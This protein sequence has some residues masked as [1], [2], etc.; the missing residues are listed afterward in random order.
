MQASATAA[1]EYVDAE[2]V[3]YTA[4]VSN[5]GGYRTGQD[6]NAGLNTDRIAPDALDG[7]LTLS[8]GEAAGPGSVSLTSGLAG[9]PDV[10]SPASGRLTTAL[11][12][13][14]D[15][16][17]SQWSFSQPGVYCVPV[18]WT[19][20]KAG[21]G[22]PVSVRKVLTFAAGVA[23]DTGITS[24]SRGQKL[25]GQGGGQAAGDDAWRVPNQS[26][27][28]SGATILNSGHIDIASTLNG[29]VFGT[30]VKDTT[31]VATG[32]TLWRD[33]ARTV[34]QLLPA[35][36]T[37]VPDN[38]RYAFLGRAG[39]RL[40]QVTETQQTELGLLWPGWSTESIPIDATQSGVTW[41]LD[42]I[43]GPGEFALYK[44]GRTLG[45]VDVLFNTR[46]G[47][48]AADSFEIAKNAHVHGAW[49]F[50]AE[51]AYCLAFTR[52]TALADG[53]KASDTFTLA[54]AVGRVEVKKIDPA[55]CFSGAGEPGT[56]DSA[57]VPES[58]LT[59]AS[60][61]G[62]QV[63]GDESG[64]SPGQQA[65]V[66]VGKAR[67]GQWVSAWLHSRPVWL[68]WAQVDDAGAAQVRL[69]AD[70]AP[71]AHKVVV[72]ARDGSLIGWDS[73]AVVKAP[74]SGSGDGDVRG[75]PAGPGGS[76]GC[77]ARDTTI[78]SSG[79][80]DYS[81][82]VV[83]VRIES[84]L[85]DSSS[86]TEVFRE[87]SKTVLWL[88]PSSK[89][90]LPAGYGQIGSA[91]S[92]AF[93]VPQTQNPELIWLGWS[94][95]T[96][97]AATVSSPVTWKLTDVDGPGTVKVFLDGQFGG[98]QSMVF[99]GAGS[100]GIRA[101][102]HAH[103]NW[104]FSEA[105]VYRLHF[106]QS[107][108]LTGGRE[109]SDSEIVT[110]VVGDVDPVT[111]VPG[112]RGCVG[113]LGG[114]KS[115]GQSD[116]GGARAKPAV[117]QCASTGVSVISA[118]H[119]DWNA[120]V[121]GGKLES[122]IGDDSTGTRLYREPDSTVLW[123]KPASRVTL[124]A[125]FS[126][127]GPPGAAVWQVPQTQ[128]DNLIWLGW[129]T[130][131]LNAGNA[132]GPVTWSLTRVDGPGSVKVYTVGSF[133][134]LQEMV[135]DGAGSHTLPLGVHVH[136][137]WAFS[138]PGVYRLHFTQTATLAQGQRSSDSEVLTVAVGDAN[139]DTA[140]PKAPAAVPSRTRW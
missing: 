72:K 84:Y 98:I 86:G 110:V 104:A 62:V 103:A 21:S 135:F 38:A 114:V 92:S 46:D 121:I 89:V 54:V 97:N 120:Q 2:D 107:A 126:Q 58:Q 65:S 68:G 71:G 53:S 95:E 63:L 40:W 138:A 76:S 123:L 24:C 109:S 132:S 139:P 69:P 42:K 1:A 66:Q 127:I 93:M 5:L 12:A 101:G 30:K 60:A 17:V 16:Q 33:P 82:Q 130:E 41:T 4:T 55:H 8:I 87:P 75:D 23:E 118:G 18:T 36:E 78:V 20:T 51:G 61:G 9:T 102:V 133:G 88:K 39:S 112:G 134:S 50:S 3:V 43:Q 14:T 45:S 52:S 37:A 115:G 29:G 35:S 11:P 56:Q 83:N 99:D 106:T 19:A 15:N 22:T 28:D 67:A 90:T 74:D 77:S 59:D 57:P 64:F 44:G 94:T 113:G 73:L 140:L 105:G 49:A 7:P 125:G 100:Y 131:L 70:A 111:A 47:V 124:P 80:L 10:L 96:L 122:L 79:H 31:S 25:T 32:E 116:T 27:T 117:A 119:L 137:N 13:R 81:T 85:G 136:A 129:S 48:T 108:T 128:N 6:M 34:L 26:T 91:G